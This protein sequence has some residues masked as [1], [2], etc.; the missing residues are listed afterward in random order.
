MWQKVKDAFWAMDDQTLKTELDLARRRYKEL[1]RESDRRYMNA[2]L[3]RN[4]SDNAMKAF[5]E[6]A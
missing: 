4:V 3:A 6:A 2:V 1:Q 5:R